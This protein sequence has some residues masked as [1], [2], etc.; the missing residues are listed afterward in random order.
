MTVK[1]SSSS[2]EKKKTN[3]TTPPAGK[4]YSEVAREV[5][6]KTDGNTKKAIEKLQTLNCPS[7]AA[8]VSRIASKEGY[9]SSP[10]KKKQIKIKNEKPSKKKSAKKPARVV[11][12]EEFE[13]EEFEEEEEEEFE[14]EF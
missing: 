14:E 8:I 2:K 1:K 6:K 7:A 11:E 3:A 12:E 10:A 13:E 9:T 5:L 4:S